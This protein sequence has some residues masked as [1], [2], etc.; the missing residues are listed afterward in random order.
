MTVAAP[1]SA[2]LYT[3]ASG[4]RGGKRCVAACPLG[5]AIG[6]GLMAALSSTGLGALITSSPAA[7]VGLQVASGLVLVWLGI[8]SW[9]AGA[10]NLGAAGKA[11]KDGSEKTTFAKIFWSALVLQASNPMLIVFL[12]SLMPPFIKADQPYVP[13]AALLCVLFMV[14]CFIVHFAY[15][16]AAAFGAERFAGPKFAF[17]LNRVS[18]VLF[19]ALGASVAWHAVSGA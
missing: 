15:S 9:R 19:W 2:V 4:F 16:A 13:Q 8:Q 6:C 12:L 10:V 3:I 5:T 11:A 1:G 17:W 7:Y 14:V 18:A